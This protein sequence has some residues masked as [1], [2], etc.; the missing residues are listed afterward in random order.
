MERYQRNIAEAGNTLARLKKRVNIL[1]LSRLGVILLGVALFFWLAQIASF[2]ALIGLFMALILCFAFLVRKQSKVEELRVR[3][4]AFAEINLNEIRIAEGKSN[5]Y[6]HGNIYQNPAHPY[7]DDL[8]IYG[9]GSI[10]EMINRAATRQGKD[11]LASYLSAPAG[12]ENSTLTA[13]DPPTLQLIEMRQK[14]VVELVADRDWCQQFQVDL[15]HAKQDGRDLKNALS[16]Y[17]SGKQKEFGN[18]LL[19]IYIRFAPYLV[20]GIFAV[21]YWFPLLFKFGIWLAIAHLLFSLGYAAR[22]SQI[23][24]KF[25][26]ISTLLRTVGKAVGSIEDKDWNSSMMVKLA[27]RI[28]SG[29]V[30][31]QQ[32]SLSIRQLAELLEKLDYRLNMLVGALMNMV[33]LWDFRQVMALQEWQKAHGDEVLDALDVIG[34]T[35]AL[36]SFAIFAINHPTWSFPEVHSASE[37]ML[38][39]QEMKHPLLAPDFAIANN[40]SKTDHRIA[41]I[42]GS[43]MA[44]KSTFLRTVGVNTV[45]AL[46]GAP[47]CAKAMQVSVMHLITYM[48]IKDSL[49]ESTS[50]FKAELDRM[51][52][53]LQTIQTQPASY[54]LIDE[55]LRGTN[56]VDK[57]KGSKAIIERLIQANATGMVATHDLQLSRLEEAHPGVIRNY[58]FDIQV[59]EGEM[60][61]DYKLKQ[62]ECKVFNASLL[63]RGI[64]IEVDRV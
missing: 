28:R 15:F 3:W 10:Y 55:M 11:R 20:L 9:E 21:S 58:H 46:A 17:V 16:H 49:Q 26:K 52:M 2:W 4:N 7:S 5:I 1:A 37:R 22:V 50:T 42:T 23:G 48:R 19:S 56:S 18:R 63:L 45:L 47:V 36:M 8:D 64:G 33:F 61:F 14:A 31:G 44:G 27:E 13:G 40:Y 29:G 60:L 57:F 24:G 41:L 39:F 12:S 53:L 62:G 43:N 34:E 32:V 6:D 51:K 35:E 30:S 54:F 59:V 25:D 38:V